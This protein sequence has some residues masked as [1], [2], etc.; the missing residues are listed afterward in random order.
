M[1][2]RRLGLEVDFAPSTT[3]PFADIDI[4]HMQ[5]IG[6]IK[7]AQILEGLAVGDRVV[8]S[9]QFLIDSESNIESALSRMDAMEVD[10]PMD[11]SHHQMEPQ[12]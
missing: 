6:F 3:N 8:T 5:E 11:H 1:H 12:Q 7:S 4:F 9:G 10:E 2:G